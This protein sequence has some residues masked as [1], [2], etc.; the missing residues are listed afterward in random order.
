MVI[1]DGWGD[2]RKGRTE[3]F[4]LGF[5]L[6][7]YKPALLDPEPQMVQPFL[8]LKRTAPE[9]SIAVTNDQGRV[10]AGVRSSE[11]RSEVG[12]VL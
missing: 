6:C 1:G 4:C 2:G 7:V 11:P 9:V 12:G 5:G 3:G 8:E 10:S